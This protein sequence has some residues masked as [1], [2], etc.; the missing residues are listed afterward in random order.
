LPALI[1]MT[2]LFDQPN[3]QCAWVRICGRIEF[4]VE[5]RLRSPDIDEVDTG[6]NARQRYTALYQRYFLPIPVAVA[7]IYN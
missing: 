4:V 1:A 2:G 3:V 6:Q 7:D 5:D